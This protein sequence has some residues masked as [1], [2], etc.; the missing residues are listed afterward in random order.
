MHKVGRKATKTRPKRIS[1]LF[2]R[3][4]SRSDKSTVADLEAKLE[5]SI[6]NFFLLPIT[7]DDVLKYLH[8]I[9][10]LAHWIADAFN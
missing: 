6:L 4:G 9:V 7:N 3:I 10:Y 5:A 2:Q 1:K 8:I